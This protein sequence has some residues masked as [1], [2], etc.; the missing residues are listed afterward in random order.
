MIR[1]KN[2]FITFI[3]SLV[4]GAGEMYLGFMK[5]GLSIMCLAYAMFV[6]GTWMD[7]SW[8]VCSISILWFYSL[9]N[10]HNKVC[11]PDEEFYLLEDDY[12]FRL[13]R[14]LPDEKLN[15][16][17]TKIFGWLLVL[18]GIGT[19]WRSSIRNLLAV[20]RTYVSHDFAEVVGNYLYNLPQFVVAAVLIVSGI[21]LILKKKSE[22]S[23]D[24]DAAEQT[25]TADG[26]KKNGIF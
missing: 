17:Q 15:G 12:L 16:K 19:I 23:A 14:I 3:C 4:P 22:F 2:G 9:F 24:T 20:L 21:R 6:A 7:A 13:E 25:E 10:V 5:E 26:E 11:L 8:L 18:F 1:K